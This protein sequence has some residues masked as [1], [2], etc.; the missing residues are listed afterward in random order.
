MNSPVPGTVVVYGPHY[1][2][3]GYGFIARLWA[4]ALH[5]AGLNVRVVPV[6]CNDPESTGGLDDTV[7]DQAQDPARVRARSGR[8]SQN[9]T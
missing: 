1:A 5:A 3:W 6:D 4:L 9:S 7:I 8:L 2:R